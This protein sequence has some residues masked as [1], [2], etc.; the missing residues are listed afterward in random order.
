[1]LPL[2]DTWKFLQNFNEPERHSP[3]H[4]DVYEGIAIEFAL[5]TVGLGFLFLVKFATFFDKKVRKKT[6]KTMF[7][8][9]AAN[10]RGSPFVCYT[11]GHFKLDEEWNCGNSWFCNYPF[12]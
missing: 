12:W 6:R 8:L 3:A 2:G 4:G 7:F 9:L 11:D 5:L 10:F 1:V